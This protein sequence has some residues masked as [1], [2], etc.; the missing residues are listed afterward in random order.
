MGRWGLWARI[1]RR[2]AVGRIRR[3]WCCIGICD[4]LC[5]AEERHENESRENSALHGDGDGQGTAVEAAFTAA[6]FGMAFDQ[7]AA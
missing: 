7:T 5:L 2:G 1:V 4:A 6:L 3:Y